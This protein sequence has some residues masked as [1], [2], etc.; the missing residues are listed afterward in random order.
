[1]NVFVAMNSKTWGF[2]RGLETSLTRQVVARYFN[3]L[4]RFFAVTV[5]CESE[6][7]WISPAIY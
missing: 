1:M 2:W 3:G 5:D 6:D 4:L 7:A